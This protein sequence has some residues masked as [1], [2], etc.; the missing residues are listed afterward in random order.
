MAGCEYGSEPLDFIKCRTFLKPSVIDGLLA[1]HE[2]LCSM[3]VNFL[4]CFGVSL[5]IV[6]C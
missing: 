2:R 3:A 4:I 6:F 1:S 5:P